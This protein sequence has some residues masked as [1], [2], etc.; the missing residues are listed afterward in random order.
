MSVGRL[1]AIE[2]KERSEAIQGLGGVMI[3]KVGGRVK[4]VSPIDWGKTSLK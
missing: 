4:G 1:G 3:E 2:G